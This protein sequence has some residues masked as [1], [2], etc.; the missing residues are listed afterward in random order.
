MLFA[1]SESEATE[2]PVFTLKVSYQNSEP[3][4]FLDSEEKGLCGDIYRRLGERLK[5]HRIA[6]DLPKNLTPIKR[7]LSNLEHGREHIFC[8]AGRNKDREARFIYST[9]PVY[10]VSNV[11][12]TRREDLYNPKS[13]Q[14][15]ADT[16]D[17]VGVFYGT[18]SA[19]FLLKHGTVRVSESH[20]DLLTALRNVQNLEKITLRYFYYHDLGLF[21]FLKKYNLS[22]LRVV[23]TKFRT[24]PQWMLFSKEIPAKVR[25]TID[26]EITAMV[27]AGEVERIWDRYKP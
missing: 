5:K 23:P 7:I 4:Y 11:V 12:V 14:D 8:G 22:G 15:L 18:S 26:A 25:Q 10:H 9:S 13:I 24:V 21:Y 27:K 2:A 17:L 3:K 19:K 6:I 16:K 20:M 1:W